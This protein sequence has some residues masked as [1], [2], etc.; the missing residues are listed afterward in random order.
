MA[1]HQSI[2]GATDEEFM[3]RMVTTYP[4][5]FGESFWVYFA[6]EVGAFLPSTSVMVDLGCGPGLFL[7][8]IATR[9]PH[10]TLY[11]YDVTPVM[12]T[13]AEGLEWPA[14]TPPL[15]VHDVV[16]E[17]LP[18]AAGSVHLVSMMSV[19]HLFDDPLSVLV[20]IRRVLAPD[21]M[22]F[23]RDWIR[24]PLK[25][26]LARRQANMGEAP[27]VSRQRGFRLF[28]V[29]NKYTVEDWEWLL[30]EAGFTIRSRMQLRPTHQIFVATVTGDG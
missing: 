21:G 19:L 13:H 16:T 15:A 11:G 20:E 18:L 29:H 2:S 12:I 14:A 24:S 27:V 25:D 30:S 1:T 17:P 3:Q 23:L 4:E 5:R 26:Y 8:D 10:A 22:F 6:S 7:R 9:Y 28:P